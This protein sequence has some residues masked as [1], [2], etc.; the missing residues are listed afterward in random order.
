MAIKIKGI[1]SGKIER[2]KVRIPNEKLR[3]SCGKSLI[4]VVL[5]CFKNISSLCSLSSAVVFFLLRFTLYLPADAPPLVA[6]G[7]SKVQRDPI[8]HGPGVPKLLLRLRR[9]VRSHAGP[10]SRHLWLVGE[11]QLL[12][13]CVAHIDHGVLDLRRGSLWSEAL[14]ASQQVGMRLCRHRIVRVALYR[15]AGGHE[16]LVPRVVQHAELLQQR[17]LLL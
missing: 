11:L 13:G 10:K 4:I 7:D 5:K 1:W 12:I 3:L 8:G 2:G 6:V 14:E 16:A 9:Q 17:N 15:D